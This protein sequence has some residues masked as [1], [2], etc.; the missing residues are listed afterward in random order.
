MKADITLKPIDAAKPG[1]A[2]THRIRVGWADCDPARIAY[3]GRLPVFALEAV[4]AWWGHVVGND[5]FSLNVDRNYGTPFV[6]LD[7][8]FKSPVTPRFP[9]DCTVQLMKVGDKSVTFFVSG[10][11]NDVLCF[12]GTFVSAFVVA[13]RFQPI[14]VP[15]DIRAIIEP[16][17]AG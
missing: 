6:H 4:D 10:F 8:D 2:F 1:S 9:L 15:D 12:Q 3:T 17:V 7:L 11:Q 13:D 14:R 16:L 5:W